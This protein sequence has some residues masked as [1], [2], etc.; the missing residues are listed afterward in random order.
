[1]TQQKSGMIAIVG[2]PNVGKSTLANTLSGEKIAIVSNKPQTTRRRVCAIANRG[3]SQFV[4]LD[5]PGLHRARS[6]LGEYMVKVVRQSVTDV[7]A[8]VLLVEPE[9]RVG[10]PEADLIQ[11]I[12]TAQIP[13]VLAINKI[14]LIPNERQLEIMWAYSRVYTFDAV[15]PLCAQTG[16]GVEELLD[17][18]EHFLPEGPPLFPAD[19]V[20]DQPE[21]VI[22]AEIIR[23]KLLLCLEQ[24]VPHGTAVEITK[25]SVRDHGLI[26]LDAVIY[27]EK[28]SHKGIIIGHRGAKLKQISTLAREDIETFLDTRVYLQTWVK[29]RE[30]W[31]DNPALIRNF[32]YGDL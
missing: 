12:Q 26:D 31:R 7:D 14:D 1:M 15:L 30:N 22:C 13:A 16:A 3:E 25:F 17:E 6:R 19:M 11:Q 24:E 21:R 9:A 4:F 10:A 8:V 23:E 32:G 18:L 20:T 27:C 2:R 28:A 5:T 29:V